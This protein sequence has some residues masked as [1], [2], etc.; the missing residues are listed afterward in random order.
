MTLHGDA[1]ARELLM[2]APSEQLAAGELDVDTAADLE[3]AR[4]LFG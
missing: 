1:G 2:D 3:Q 4:T